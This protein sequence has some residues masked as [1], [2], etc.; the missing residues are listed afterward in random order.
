MTPEEEVGSL[1]LEMALQKVKDYRATSKS[2]VGGTIYMTILIEEADA[3]IKAAVRRWPDFM[4]HVSRD[5]HSEILK[6]PWA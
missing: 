3:F 5:L 6:K 2:M 1:E 4:D